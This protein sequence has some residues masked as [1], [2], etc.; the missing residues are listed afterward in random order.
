MDIVQS[1]DKHKQEKESLTCLVTHSDLLQHGGAEGWRKWSREENGV[2]GQLK[3]S[4]YITE[5]QL[6]RY[7]FSGAIF[8][9]IAKASS[10]FFREIHGFM[11][12]VYFERYFGLV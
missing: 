4:M 11:L 12:L 3:F 6:P 10:C 7:F 1:N 2:A 8:K 9:V 5:D